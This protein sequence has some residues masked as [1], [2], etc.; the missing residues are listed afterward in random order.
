MIFCFGK[1]KRLLTIDG[2]TCVDSSA[3]EG[4]QRAR[5]ADEEK[6]RDLA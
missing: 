4:L 6:V 3:D 1:Y 5:L 2:T